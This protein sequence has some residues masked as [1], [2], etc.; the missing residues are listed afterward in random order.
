[1][2]DVWIRGGENNNN[3]WKV[4]SKRCTDTEHQKMEANMSEKRSLALYNELKCKE[5]STQTFAHSRKEKVLDGGRWVS[6]G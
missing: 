2:G 1:M 5:K 3:I 4:V 6:G